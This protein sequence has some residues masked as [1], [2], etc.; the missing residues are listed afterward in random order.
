MGG[1]S[2]SGDGP[3]GVRGL[4]PRSRRSE[5]ANRLGRE[6]SLKEDRAIRQVFRRGK[7]FKGRFLTVY[8]SRGDDLPLKICLKVS[9]RFGSAP[10]RNYLKRIIRE[11]IR[12]NRREF[13]PC[14]HMVIS[15]H[16]DPD[17]KNPFK[18]IKE[19]LLQFAQTQ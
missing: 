5:G 19:E 6:F 7:K 18:L 10:R 16:V 9:R 1:K 15:A 17:H 3:K 11:V 8:H 12:L 4:R 13:D 14:G 2:S